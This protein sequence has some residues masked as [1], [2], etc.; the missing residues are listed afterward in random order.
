MN[1]KNTGV[2]TTVT[3]ILVFSLIL[4]LFLTTKYIDMA[5][6]QNTMWRNAITNF[7]KVINWSSINSGDLSNNTKD[8]EYRLAESRINGRLL[9]EQLDNMQILPYA[10]RIFPWKHQEKLRLFIN[11]NLKVVGLMEQELKEQGAVSLENKKR[12]EIIHNTWE[13]ILRVLET[14]RNKRNPFR[15][16]FSSGTWSRVFD[17]A[18]TV[19]DRVELVPL[20]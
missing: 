5:K 2:L 8:W 18:M 6:R 19:F 4:N 1:R 12:A 16:V 9:Q 17:E 7:A 13:E 20:P 3:V 10:D 14:E 15:P 11:Y